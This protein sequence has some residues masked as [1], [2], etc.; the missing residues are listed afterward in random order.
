MCT[1]G[2][3]W[4]SEWHTAPLNCNLF[5]LLIRREKIYI[6]KKA[7]RASGTKCILDIYKAGPVATKRPKQNTYQPSN[8]RDCTNES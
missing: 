7:E 8:M 2:K 5:F 1:W 4:R 6:H 3:I